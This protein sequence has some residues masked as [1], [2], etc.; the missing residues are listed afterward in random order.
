MSVSCWEAVCLFVC[1]FEVLVL[2]YACGFVLWARWGFNSRVRRGRLIAKVTH[3]FA[4]HGGYYV[5]EKC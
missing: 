4:M 2:M 1:L 3:I 5:E